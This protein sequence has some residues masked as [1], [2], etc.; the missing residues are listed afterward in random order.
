MTQAATDKQN[1][2]TG[3]GQRVLDIVLDHL[4]CYPT[5]GSETLGKDLL[6][7]AEMGLKKYGT[8]LLTQNGRDG[9]VDVYQEVQD[10]LMYAMACRAE[11]DTVGG[12]YVEIFT[13]IA[14]RMADDLEKREQQR[15]PIAR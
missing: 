6:A 3:N 12:Q 2:P 14:C 15:A 8:Y 13:A 11:G 5:R 9:S 4:H 7:R 1:P 10:A